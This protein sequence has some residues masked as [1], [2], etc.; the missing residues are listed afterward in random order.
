MIGVDIA[1][2]SASQSFELSTTAITGRATHYL[3]AGSSGVPEEVYID[4]KRAGAEYPAAPVISFYLSSPQLGD[5]TLQAIGIDPFAERS[6]RDLFFGENFSQEGNLSALLTTPNTVLISN[7]LADY[8]Q[9]EYGSKIEIVVGGRSKTVTVVGIVSSI[10]S[11]N[12]RALNDL[13]VMDISTAQEITDKIGYLDRV[14]LILPEDQPELIKSFQENLPPQ[15]LVLPIESRTG[16]VQELTNAFQ[17]NLTALSLLAMVVA[18]FLIYNT[19]AFS[20]IQRRPMFGVLRSL[21]LTRREIFLLVIFESFLVGISGAFLG[22]ILGIVMGQGTIDLV[23]QTINDLFFVTTIRNLPLPIRSIIKGNLVGIS[24]TM[25]M[26][27]FPAWEAVRIPPISSITRSKLEI[28]INQRIPWITFSGLMILLTGVGILLIPTNNLVVSFGGT[29]LVIVGLAMLTPRVIIS[30]MNWAGKVTERIWGALGRIAPREVINSLS[31]TAIDVAALMI[32][33]AVTIGVSLMINS[34][35]LTVVTWLDQILQ[36]DIYISVAGASVSQPIYSL[37][38][39]ILAKLDELED[40]KEVYTLQTSLIESPN[41]PIQVAANNNPNDGQEQIYLSSQ[42]PPEQI[43]GEL[44]KGSV[45]I[46]EPL[47]NRL[48]LPVEGGE[49]QLITDRGLVAFPIAGVFYDYSSSQ[50]SALF[51]QKTY[52]EYWSDENISAAS[53]ILKPGIDVDATTQSLKETFSGGQRL[54]IR[55]NQA[56]KR[57]TLEIFDRTFAI[58]ATLQFMTTIVAFIGVLSAIMTL[59]ID[60]QRQVGILRALGLTARQLWTLV[61]IETGLMGAAAGILAVPTGYILSLILI[62]IINQR[63]FGWTLQLQLDPAPFVGA[64]L[65]AVTASI[66]AGILPTRR[67]LKQ[68]PS[69]AIRFE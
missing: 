64:I 63:S 27:A 31:R 22:T 46:S 15:V 17:I 23:T 6:F 32:A 2:L 43:W 9:V 58:T 49:L 40:I 36:G 57:E 54:L 65:L 8:Y 5:V 51:A 19:M 37:D 30:L 33:V 50:G 10:D 53:L 45:L 14:E 62:Y 48:G 20:V 26:A 60:K 52:Q 29:F 55:P 12:Q 56:L 13:L 42:V 18:L 38:P 67:I 34:F 4:L 3:S 61:L 68:Q 21:G 69:E 16:I 66:L 1:N 59:Q 24:A 47:M 41:G 39:D 28:E 7:S 35:R 44:E 11:L 25:I